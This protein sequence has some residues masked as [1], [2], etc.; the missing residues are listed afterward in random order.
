MENLNKFDK[1]LYDHHVASLMILSVCAGAVAAMFY[2]AGM[3]ALAKGL[4][5][6][7]AKSK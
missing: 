5:E 3:L 1:F 4:N 7:L 2:R 6:E